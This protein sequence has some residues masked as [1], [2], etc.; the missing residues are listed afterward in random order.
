MVIIVIIII[1]VIINF[2]NHYHP[3]YFP[4][5]EYLNKTMII[6]VTLL[7]CEVWYVALREEHASMVEMFGNKELRKVF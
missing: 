6:R 2:E 5:D 4:K 3:V 1:I 7:G